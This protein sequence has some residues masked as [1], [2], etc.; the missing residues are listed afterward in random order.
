FGSRKS[1]VQILSPRLAQ[2]CYRIM[3]PDST[4]LVTGATGFIGTWLVKALVD[5]GQTVRALSRRTNPKPPPGFDG[6]AGGPLGHPRVE[7]VQGDIRHPEALVRAAE[8]CRY[9]FHV[10]GYAKNWAAR[11]E[12]FFELN[13]VGMHN[14]LDAA[15][16]AGAQRIVW[17]SSIVTLGPTRPGEVGNEAMPRIS[18]RCFTAYEASKLQAER[19]ALRRAEEGLPLVVVN[20]TRVFGPGHFTEGNALTQLI[21]AYDRDRMPVLLNRGVNVGNYVLV[22]D[23]VQG[24]LLAM[25]KGRI[26][27][28][29]I[30]GGDNATLGEFFQTIDRVSGRR[31]RQIPLWRFGPLLYAWL[32]EKR[33]EWFGVYPRITPGWIRTFLADWMYTSQKAQQELGYQPTPL[34]EGIRQTYAWL[35]GLRREQ[36]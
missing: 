16:A 34:E 33:A 35:L 13:V 27:Q 4:V 8:G 7:L 20:P 2:T 15:V 29:Y 30:L 14:V 19:E 23:V 32:Q 21:D 9:V 18:D 31:H 36:R 25:E 12:T 24:H 6:P 11:R 5:R 3:E 1:E 17:T 22:D 28:R 26:G 10:A